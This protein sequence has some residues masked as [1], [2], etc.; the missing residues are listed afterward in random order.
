MHKTFPVEPGK[1]RPNR[2]SLEMGPMMN[3]DVV[4]EAQKSLKEGAA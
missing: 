2:S 4:A 1:E 3:Y